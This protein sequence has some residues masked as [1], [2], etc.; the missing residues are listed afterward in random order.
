MNRRIKIFIK[1]LIPKKMRTV[2]AWSRQS[3][4]EQSSYW[5]NFRIVREIYQKRATGD[6]TLSWYT[7]RAQKRSGPFGRVLAFGDGK[8]MAAEAALMRNDT[9]EVVYFNISK[10]E[11]QEFE[12]LF[13]SQHFDFPFRHVRGDANRFDFA[14]L[15]A[16][17]TIIT[18]GTFHHFEK[19][20]RIFPQ[21]NKIL[22]PDGLL[23]ADEFI[24]PSR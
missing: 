22:N 24:G 9:Q 16:F 5:G 17:D 7:S 21:L 10:R 23:Y 19:F 15:G 1:S 6:P 13:S 11:C 8:G 20:E 3:T 12:R 18:V 14:T 4:A 2:L